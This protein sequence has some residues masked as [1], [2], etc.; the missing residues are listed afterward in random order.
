MY[1]TLIYKKK[2]LILSD[3]SFILKLI[4]VL[5]FISFHENEALKIDNIS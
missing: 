5:T 1:L 4:L 3:V 2:K